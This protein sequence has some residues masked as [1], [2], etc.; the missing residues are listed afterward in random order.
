MLI[1]PKS[2]EEIVKE[3]LAGF[4]TTGSNEDARNIASSLLNSMYESYMRDALASVIMWTAEDLSKFTWG[5]YDPV[6]TL[7]DLASSVIKK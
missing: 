3:F 7:R 4:Q 6:K 5:P 2:P 1:V